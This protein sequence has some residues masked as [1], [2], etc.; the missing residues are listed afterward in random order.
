MIRYPIHVAFTDEV[1]WLIGDPITESKDMAE[2][3]ISNQV[4]A[5]LFLQRR[6][7]HKIRVKYYAHYHQYNCC[8]NR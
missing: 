8:R 4:E 2:A 6:Q 3:H 5:K 1:E 7:S